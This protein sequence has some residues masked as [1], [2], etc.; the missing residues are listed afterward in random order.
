MAALLGLLGR[1]ETVT[2]N[3]KSILHFQEPSQK[4]GQWWLGEWKDNAGTSLFFL[5]P[6]LLRAPMRNLV[7]KSSSPTLHN[8]RLPF[9]TF[10][11]FSLDWTPSQTQGGLIICFLYF[12]AHGWNDKDA[13]L[14]NLFHLQG[15]LTEGNNLHLSYQCTATVTE[16]HSLW[17]VFP[18]EGHALS[19]TRKRICSALS[20]SLLT[21]CTQ[22]IR[23][24]LVARLWGQCCPDPALIHTGTFWIYVLGPPTELAETHSQRATRPGK[25]KKLFF[26]HFKCATTLIFYIY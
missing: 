22:T 24:T 18:P 11:T 21:K 2:M 5:Q 13:L 19:G 16:W 8:S 15:F 10:L 9:L 23:E 12:R 7:V 4:Q 25:E 20:G 1:V 17:Q 3:G 6:C 26:T 14:D